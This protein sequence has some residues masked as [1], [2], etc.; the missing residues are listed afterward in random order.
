MQNR[1]THIC[2]ALLT[3][4]IAI[5]CTGRN[6]GVDNPRN[7]QAGGDRGTY[8]RLAL[9]GCVQPAP[10]GQG[11]ALTHVVIVPATEQPQGQE[12]MEHPLISRGSWVRLD[13][14]ANMNEDLKHYLNN[15]VAI[16][17]DVVDR[18]TNTIGTS[19]HGGTPPTAGVANGAAPKIAVEKV[20]KVA[21]NC[22][23]E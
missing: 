1:L 9:R 2:V 14:G 20:S 7:A 10:A 22:A 23:G 21:E 17:G 19:G 11:L 4:G 5:A 8:E 18:G 12:M 6:N 16:A 3:A 15:E 13:A